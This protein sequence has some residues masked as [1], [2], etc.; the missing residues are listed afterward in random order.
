MQ[1]QTARGTTICDSYSARIID[2][3][4]LRA[5]RTLSG[6]V[7]ELCDIFLKFDTKLLAHYAHR[8]TYSTT[9]SPK[10]I[11]PFV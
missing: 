10:Q 9:F 5:A 4:V 3:E 7:Q 2:W 1:H 11:R 8:H 6:T